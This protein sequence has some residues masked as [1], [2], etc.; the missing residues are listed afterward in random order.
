MGRGMPK[1]RVV[2]RNLKLGQVDADGEAP[3]HEVDHAREYGHHAQGRYEGV[4]L[5]LRDEQPVHEADEG[6]HSKAHAEPQ[7]VVAVLLGEEANDHPRESRYPA[8]GEVEGPGE[9]DERLPDADNPDHRYGEA[10]GEEVLE[11]EEVGR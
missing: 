9:Q 3:A 6:P 1:T 11:V 4:Y 5:Q 7:P 2:P 8:D 10:D